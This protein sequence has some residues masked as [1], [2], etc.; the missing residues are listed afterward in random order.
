MS[1]AFTNEGFKTFR[2]S[3]AACSVTTCLP[4][5]F[6]RN[7]ESAASA[8]SWAKVSCV[9]SELSCLGQD[10][11]TSPSP[12]HAW[13]SASA[14]LNVQRPVALLCLQG[15]IITPFPDHLSFLPRPQTTLLLCSLSHTWDSCLQG[16]RLETC[17]PV[18]SFCCKPGI[19]F[20]F[21]HIW[22]NKPGGNTFT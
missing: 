13:A 4:K 5:L 6:F 18:S 11:T 20:D 9:C 21:L 19:C 8:S 14:L 16:S 15:T 1:P 22:Q 10:G 17:F 7:L 3:Q 2:S 12:G